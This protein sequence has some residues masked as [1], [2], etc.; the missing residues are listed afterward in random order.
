MSIHEDIFYTNVKTKDFDATGKRVLDV[1]FK[2][3]INA[4]SGITFNNCKVH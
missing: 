3:T 1:I 2:G 4:V